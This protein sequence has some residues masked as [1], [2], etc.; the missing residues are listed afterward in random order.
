M[1]GEATKPETNRMS[2]FV[3]SQ[4]VL[5]WSIK[6]LNE[7]PPP[8]KQCDTGLVIAAMPNL[9]ETTAPFIEPAVLRSAEEIEREEEN[10]Y[11]IHCQ[12]NQ[13]IRNGEKLLEGYDKNVVSFRHYGF[14]W[15][16]GYCG[17]SWD[18]V[19]PDT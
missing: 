15:V 5:L 11:D 13:A 18:E 10:I 12:V 14:S 6:K 19:T 1:N 17:Q 3:E 4:F 7:L 8:T 9:F 2:W 16:Q